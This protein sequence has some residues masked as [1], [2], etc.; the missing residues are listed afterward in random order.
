V[1]VV[2]CAADGAAWSL[3]V[4]RRQLVFA[5]LLFPRRVAQPEELCLRVLG[6]MPSS[7]RSAG[8]STS[9]TKI[10]GLLLLLAVRMSSNSIRKQEETR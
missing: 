4:A 6:G 5:C 3:S 8:C 9:T 2:S 10:L 1:S 7:N